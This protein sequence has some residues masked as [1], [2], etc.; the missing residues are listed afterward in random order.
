MSERKQSYM[1]ELDQWSEA[2]VIGPL[3]SAAPAAQRR[4]S[5]E[6]DKAVQSVKRAIRAKVLESYHNGQQST[7][8]KAV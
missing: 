6:W 8:R 2:T 5:A 1:A 7:E 3:L 4:D